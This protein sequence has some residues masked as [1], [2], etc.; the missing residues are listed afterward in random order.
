MVS[1]NEAF[2]QLVLKCHHGYCMSSAGK[3]RS[4]GAGH[5]ST[6]S[7]PDYQ[8]SRLAL[9]EDLPRRTRTDHSVMILVPKAMMIDGASAVIPSQLALKAVKPVFKERAASSLAAQ[10]LKG[11]EGGRVPHPIKKSCP[12]AQDTFGRSPQQMERVIEAIN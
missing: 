1:R 4:R 7:S 2:A 6:I 12:L 9:V 5:K 11:R 3:W 8:Q 10:E